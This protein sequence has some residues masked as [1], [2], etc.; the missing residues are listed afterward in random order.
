VA[1]LLIESCD[2]NPLQSQIPGSQW[3]L[4]SESADIDTIFT[5]YRATTFGSSSSLYVGTKDNIE[6]GSLIRFTMPDS[7]KMTLSDA[8]SAALYI[9]PKDSNLVMGN[10]VLGLVAGP[11][12]SWAEGDTGLY[13]GDF[14]ADPIGVSTMVDSSVAYYTSGGVDTAETP[15]VVFS[16]DVDILVNW[17]A[18][19]TENAGFL[20]TADVPDKMISFYSTHGIKAPHLVI[21]SDSAALGGYLKAEHDIYVLDNDSSTTNDGLQLNFVQGKRVHIDFRDQFVPDIERPIAGGR[22][23]LFKDEN[24]Q[25]DGTN[26]NLYILTRIS[27]FSAT[28]DFDTDI[29]QSVTMPATADSLVISI[30]SFLLDVLNRRRDNFGLDLLVNPL[31]ND[32][33]QLIFHDSTATIELRPKLDILYATPYPVGE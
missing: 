12:S 16:I 15:H 32:F 23:T 28:D 10:F 20:V 2:L 11:D 33:D 17:Q 21:E 29:F 3:F 8:K 18:N 1:I 30:T 6:A 22:I 5:Y 24:S 26:V 9:F 19:S 25:L 27:E 13:L 7:T 31:N 14:S 4:E